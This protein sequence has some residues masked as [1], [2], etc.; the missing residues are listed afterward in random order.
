M[1]APRLSSDVLMAHR[2]WPARYPESSLAGVT[3]ALAAG[4]RW[5]EL[6]VQLTADGVPV[7]LHDADL[8]RTAG[9]DDCIF[10]VHAAAV[11]GLDVGEPARLG[12]GR[13]ATPLP[14]LDAM[15]ALVDDYAGAT[16]FIEAKS[17]SV[18]RFGR[19]AV[20]TALASRLD[21]AR[22]PVVIGDDVA[23]LADL[24]ERSGVRIG[25]LVAAFD[26][27]QERRARA[28]A[29]EY[30]FCC[31]AV[32]PAEDA[33]FWPGDW[34]WVVYGVAAPGRARSLLAQGAAIVETDDIGG[35]LGASDQAG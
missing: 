5:I 2:G 10:D 7:V 34:A 3:A 26:A 20:V 27:E 23:V 12:P 1:A 4:A 30:L 32:V 24:R 14:T 25:W 13:E 21:G 15:L 6:D 35:W 19:D 18:A 16:A 8:A 9:R 11:V 29:P 17:E 28:L 31:E 33:P 22:G